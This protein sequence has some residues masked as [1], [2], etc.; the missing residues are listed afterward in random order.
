MTVTIRKATE[1]NFPA[2]L[3]LV[4]ELALFENAPDSVTN[5][6]E[7]MQAE[8]DHFQ[9]LVAATDNGE[10]VGMVVYFSPILR[11]WENHYTLMIYM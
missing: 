9:A 1:A 5:T 10:I 11:G 8:Q 6:V 7:Q 4:K 3:A 2:I